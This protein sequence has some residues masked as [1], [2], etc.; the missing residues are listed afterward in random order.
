[1]T[2]D[3][4]LPA[5]VPGIDVPRLAAWLARELPGSGRITAIDLI[6]GGRSNLTY[7]ITLDGGRRVVLRRPPLGHV[8]PT[9]HDMGREYRVLSALGTGTD[10]PVPNALAF[11]DDEDVIG[12]RFYLMDF[13]EGRVLRTREDAEQITPEQARGLSDALVEALAAIHTVDVEAVGLGD[14][15]RPNGYM[16]RQL[17]RWGKQWDSSQEAIRATG[18]VRDLPEYDRL[19]ARLAERLPADGP[20]GS[21]GSSGGGWARLVHGDFRLD[22]ALARL[23]PRPE[24]AAVVDWEMSTLGDPLSDLGLTLVYWAEAADAEEL[25]VGATITSA[26]GFHTRRE[27]TDRYAALTGFDLG[28]L[29][30]YVA[31][32]CFKLAV[33]LEGIHARFLQKA[34]VGEGFDEIGGGVP[35]LLERAHRTLDTRSISS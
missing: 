27:F 13:V 23:E 10:V 32:A 19:V 16:E 14:F 1:M 6:A 5:G 26:P 30:F 31:F 4:E 18:T 3:A 25:P 15:G 8:L 2:V 28:D 9:A 11:C 24:I 34:T 17:R 29:D 21:G 22:N 35:I 33:I 20:A 12:A 7:G